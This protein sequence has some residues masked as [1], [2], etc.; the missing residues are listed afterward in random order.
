MLQFLLLFVLKIVMG[1][2][3]LIQLTTSVGHFIETK[4]ATKLWEWFISI[5][6]LQPYM[7]RLLHI[8]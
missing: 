8:E 1:H 5:G 6:L 2:V 7:H 4:V 3:K